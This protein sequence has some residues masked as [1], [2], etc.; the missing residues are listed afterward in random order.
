M[1]QSVLVS[2]GLALGARA[3]ILAPG[4]TGPH[5]VGTTVLELVD[6]SRQD[7]FAPTPQPRDLVISLFYP[8]QT[9]NC[10]L[11]PQ[12]PPA[13]AAV[14][15][16]YINATG[17]AET[18]VTRSCAGSPLTRPDLP[19][20]LF[21]P[22]LGNPRLFH[23]NIAEQLA[24]YGWNVV[25]VDHTYEAFVV[26]FPG[27]RVVTSDDSPNEANATL[28]QYLDVRVKDL[29]FVLDSLANSSV[30]SQIPG[31]GAPSASSKTDSHRC[32]KKLA[33]SKVGVFGH[34]FGGAT[35]LQ[36]LKDDARFHVGANLDGAVYGTVVQEGTDSPF[37][38][39]GAQMGAQNHSNENDET[40]AEAWKNLR[41]FKREYIVNGTQHGAF[42]DLPIFRD[43]L[44]NGAL[45]DYS[46]G[47]G[48]IKGTRIL[49]IETAF[50]GALFGRFLKGKGGELLDGKGLNKWPEVTLAH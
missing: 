28:E 3:T 10:T 23:S 14:I 46:Q 42:T 40:W 20:V 44:P 38:F 6:T 26:E 24:S 29:R 49:D 37:V 39:F 50:L 19:L 27:G 17:I 11:A 34:S 2:L 48:T 33:T 43:L 36:L 18:F 35:S 41:G 25:T 13:T 45:G 4:L 30:T 8:T 22:G 21:S 16:A 1:L 32:Q 12:F 15:D 7:P 47:L 9:T 31:L 5:K